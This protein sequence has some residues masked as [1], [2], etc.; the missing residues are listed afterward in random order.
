ML[1]NEIGMNLLSHAYE[2]LAEARIELRAKKPPCLQHGAEGQGFTWLQVLQK[3]PDERR[4]T[5]GLP[6]S[7]NDLRRKKIDA[8]PFLGQ[9][10]RH[11]TGPSDNR[12]AKRQQK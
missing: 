6:D 1:T 2:S 7:L 4:E 9:L 10:R 11:E 12:K 5:E 8:C 3:E